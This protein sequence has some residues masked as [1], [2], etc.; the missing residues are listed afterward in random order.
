[1]NRKVIDDLS[2]A[3]ANDVSLLQ[4]SEASP[5][6]GSTLPQDSVPGVVAT[7]LICEPMP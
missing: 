1:M 7:S 2:F 6:P 3:A 5:A 4:D